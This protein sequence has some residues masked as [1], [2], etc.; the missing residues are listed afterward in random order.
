MKSGKQKRAELDAKRK[1]RAAKQKQKAQ[2]SV[3]GGP[4]QRAPVNVSLLTTTYSYREPDFVARGYYLD[5]AFECVDC[6][7][8]EIW[9]ATQQKWWYEIA[10]GDIWTTAKRCRACRRRDRERRSEARRIHLEGL[11]RR[12]AERGRREPG[13]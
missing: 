11:A 8:N 13:A 4:S 5:R 7:K 6:G 12:Q 1:A 9:T 2:S 3:V 10:K